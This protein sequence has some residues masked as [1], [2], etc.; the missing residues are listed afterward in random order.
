MSLTAEFSQ[1]VGWALAHQ[2]S[3]GMTSPALFPIKNRKVD[4][5]HGLKSILQFYQ[6]HKG[7]S[8][9]VIARSAATKQSSLM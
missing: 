7:T 4:K 9:N 2:F 1:I 8:K 5:Q 3:H 6:R